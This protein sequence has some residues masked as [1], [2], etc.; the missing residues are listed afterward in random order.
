MSFA[1]EREGQCQRGEPVQGASIRQE[2][3]ATQAAAHLLELYLARAVWISILHHGRELPFRQLR[4]LELSHHTP[5]LVRRDR[6][7]PVEVELVE[8]VA[9][10]G[11]QLWPHQRALCGCRR[12]FVDRMRRGARTRAW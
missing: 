2:R 6:T 12:F 5:H 7:A 3:A 11:T 10:L 9:E 1:G 8:D 4:L